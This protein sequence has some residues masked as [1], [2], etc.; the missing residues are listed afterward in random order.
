[1]GKAWRLVL[2]CVMLL[3]ISGDALAG[4]PSVLSEDFST[5]LRL[6]SEPHQRFQ[7]ISFFLVGLLAAAGLVRVLWNVLARDFPRL[8]RLTYI[9]SL[10]LVLMWGCAF[11]VVLTMIAGARELMTP[12]AW[13]KD[14]VTFSV[15]DSSATGNA[16]G[17]SWKLKPFDGEESE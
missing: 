15:R 10:V 7:A 14:G 1:M 6:N 3:G 17:P 9:K 8:P 16:E 4:M 12:G 11:L 5:Y 13:K 2:A